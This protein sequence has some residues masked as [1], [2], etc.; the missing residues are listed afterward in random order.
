M[1]LIAAGSPAIAINFAINPPA[2]FWGVLGRKR[3][4][5]TNAG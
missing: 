5:R 1:V 4:H 2:L 3:M